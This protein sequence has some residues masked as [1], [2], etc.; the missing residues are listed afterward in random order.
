MS[1][2]G[3]SKKAVVAA[4]AANAAI[5]VAKFVA[6]FFSGSITM[7]AEGVHSVADTANQGLLLVGMGLSERRDPERYPLGRAKERYFWAFIVALML[8]FL[9]G[10][11]AIYEG[12]HKLREPAHA[13]GSQLIP[14]VV[15][16]ISIVLE[17]TSFVV[18]FREFRQQKGDRSFRDALFEAR[19]PTIPVVLLEDTGALVGLFIALVS[20]IL[21]WVT[22]SSI[23]DSVGSIVIGALLC[24]IGVLLARDT[25]SLLI[26][27]SAT[28]EMR[29]RAL[30]IMLEVPGVEAITKMLTMHLGP[31]MIVVALKVRFP[32]GMTIAECERVI[33]DLE[34]RVRA[35]IPQMKRIFVEP[36]GDYE[37]DEPM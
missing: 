32:A 8:F 28:P 27:E 10:V 31:D 2:H 35:G 29:R 3:D 7:L 25:K 22:G 5:A 4:M 9:G 18:A 17:G 14:V 1:G 15:L 16:A 11:Y 34:G 19:D 23:A 24:S 33:D 13:P 37:G 36:D 12:V 21:T 30:E 20:V 6:A 26:G